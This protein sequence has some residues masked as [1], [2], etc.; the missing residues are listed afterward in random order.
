MCWTE[1]AEHHGPDKQEG[2]SRCL[3]EGRGLTGCATRG[4][5]GQGP[6]SYPPCPPA[7]D[8]ARDPVATEEPRDCNRAACSA[9]HTQ[10]P[11]GLLCPDSAPQEEEAPP[12]AAKATRRQSRQRAPFANCLWQRRPCCLG[13]AEPEGE[14]TVKLAPRLRAWGLEC[15]ATCGHPAAGLAPAEAA[16]S[17]AQR[18]SPQHRHRG[19]GTWGRGNSDGNRAAPGENS[20]LPAPAGSLKLDPS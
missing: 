7:Q 4:S 10:A 3:R 18:L 16:T 12:S 15:P 11:R 6:L 14:G 17:P 13:L 1:R 19:S 2:V 20:A 5:R 8:S 9:G